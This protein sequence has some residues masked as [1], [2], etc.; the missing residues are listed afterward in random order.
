M[1]GLLFDSE[2]L[3]HDAIL[4]AAQELGHSF[5]TADFLKLVGRPWGVNRLALQEHIGPD[6]M[7]KR[8]T[9]PGPT[10]TKA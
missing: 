5:T 3:Y 6:G 7:S 1:D 4:A 10:T 2:T 8:S 9:L